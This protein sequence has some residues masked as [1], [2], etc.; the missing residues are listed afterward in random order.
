MFHAVRFTPIWRGPVIEGVVITPL[1]QFSDERGKVMRMLSRED[2]VFR[3]FGE[4]YFSC[5]YPDAIK[6]W[7][8]HSRMTLNY[9]VPHGRIKFVLY[10]DREGSATR[11]GRFR[12]YSSD[13]TTTAWLQCR[14]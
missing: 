3:E 5:I 10:N 4:I 13:R 2:S 14:L 8:I 7:H 12:R 9:T 11:G 6:G 1:K